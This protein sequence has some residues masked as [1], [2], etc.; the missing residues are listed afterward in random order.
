MRLSQAPAKIGASL[1]LGT[2]VFPNLEEGKLMFSLR[3]PRKGW[4]AFCLVGTKPRNVRMSFHA[5]LPRGNDIYWQV[6]HF[7]VIREGET[8]VDA[9]VQMEQTEDK[10]SA[11]QEVQIRSRFGIPGPIKVEGFYRQVDYPEARRP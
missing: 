11:G 6:D 8:E 5:V 2:K 4:W 1:G 3:V 7:V 10:L 9:C